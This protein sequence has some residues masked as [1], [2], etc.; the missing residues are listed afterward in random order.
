MS[1]TL[2]NNDKM[3]NRAAFRKHCELFPTTFKVTKEI[4]SELK[5]VL[6]QAAAGKEQPSIPY[7]SDMTVHADR[8]LV[9]FSTSPYDKHDLEYMLN[10]VKEIEGK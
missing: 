8:L 5:D 10:V 1:L 6:L 3:M 7:L 4:T 2:V 9:R